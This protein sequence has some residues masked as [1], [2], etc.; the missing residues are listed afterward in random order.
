M[1]ITYFSYSRKIQKTFAISCYVKKTTCLTDKTRSRRLQKRQKKTDMTYITFKNA[2]MRIKTLFTPPSF[3][4]AC[5]SLL[6]N[7]IDLVTIVFST[8][9]Y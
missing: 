8:G 1:M 7:D 6:T 5:P 3:L 9:L 4:L 2:A